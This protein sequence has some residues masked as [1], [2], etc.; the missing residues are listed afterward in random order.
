MSC[1]AVRTFFAMQ[2]KFSLAFIEQMC[3][4]SGTGI[5]HM[6]HRTSV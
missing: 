5:E 6:F 3:Y 4:Y 1:G 2:R